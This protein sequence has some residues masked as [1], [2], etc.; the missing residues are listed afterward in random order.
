MKAI[1]NIIYFFLC[2]LILVAC[3]KDRDFPMP[4]LPPDNALTD[5]FNYSTKT[6]NADNALTITF[7]ASASSPL[8]GYSGDV[9][10]HT[11]V[12]SE[13]V[14]MYVPAAWD[15]NIS[16]CKMTKVEDNV[17]KI[18]LA[19]SVRQWFASG[20]T[21]VVKLGM[22][23]RSADGTK[24]GIN[25]DTFLEL[26]DSKYTAFQP[27]AIKESTMPAGL[28]PGINIVNQSTV[29]FVLYDKDKNNNHK[30]FAHLVGDF[31]NWKLTN[32]DKSQMYRDNAAGCWW[33]TVSG[34]QPTQE[35]AFQYYVGTK[36]VETIRLGDAY[37]RKVL[38]P[39]N[40]KYIPASIYP[41][42]KAYPQGAIGIASVFRIQEDAY[43]WKVNN[44]V[45]ADK[46]NLVIYELL[47]RDFTST[48]DLNGAISKLDYLK[49]LGVN[50]IEL[51]P[52]QEFDGNDSWGY[53]PCFFFAMDKAY[54]TD[55][56]YKQFIDAC[57][58]RGMAVIL[59]VVYNHATGAHPFAK[60]YWDGKNNKTAANNPWFN[61]DAPHPYSVFHDF[62][63]QSPLVRDF[64]KRNLQFLLNEYKVDGFRFDLAKGFTQNSSTEATAGNYDASRVAI[65]KD[66][67][68]AIKQ[69][70]NDAIIILE[71]FADD[72]EEKELATA[73]M[74]VWRNLNNAYCQ[75]GMSWS[76]ESSFERLYTGSNGM[77]FGG[78]IG[79]MESHDE[80]RVNFK[81]KTYGN[82][83]LKTNAANRL[84]SL[85]TN[86][87]F[88]FTVPGPKMVWQFGEMAYD[89]SIEEGGRTGK[90]PL[91]W[92]YLT[93]NKVLVDN[94]TKLIRLRKA[95]PSLFSA[96]S[97]LE[98]KV[99]VND[100]NNGRTLTLRA[101]DGKILHVFG[102]FTTNAVD[103][104]IPA[105]TWFDY[106][107][108][109]S[110]TI[111]GGRSISVPA[112]EFRLYTNFD[113][114]K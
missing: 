102:N 54:G 80:E 38:D 72:R 48:G 35:Y 14:W 69:V 86:A 20:E 52:V 114:S 32:D 58:E 22:V 55:R 8:Y 111:Q 108:A 62:N 89:I 10:L 37:C 95:Y 73:G 98:W 5:G 26:T 91:H 41:N 40:D 45:V 15:Q 103:Y 25:S 11:G 65:W 79:Y 46:N 92:E 2:S 85:S 82:G 34:L 70:K 113:P 9:Y 90:K 17:W 50:A 23:I 100:W 106:S 93:T 74:Q 43:S 63:H 44:Y 105:G 110:V 101:S 3:S 47:L 75:S 94:Y 83:D 84:K 104:S 42:L 59:D 29:T 77:T 33:L 24:K 27:A 7:K 107:G 71:L 39:D 19:P 13:G 88:F 112:H 49:T 97:Q 6:P 99:G 51:M 36:G 81:V 28:K 31:N 64:V 76:S 18:D 67:S 78:C 60:L 21:P 16:K 56:M 96:S 87:A 1:K 61:V 57:H 12:I 109:T 30:D 68:S 4:P 66:Y 53:N